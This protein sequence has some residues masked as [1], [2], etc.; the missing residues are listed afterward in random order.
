VPDEGLRIDVWLWRARLF[1]TRAQAASKAGQGMIRLRRDGLESRIDKPSRTVRP[2]DE[3]TFGN[4]GRV[5]AVRILAL[6]A[7]RGPAA[8]ARL[9]FE[10]VDE[11]TARAIDNRAG[12]HR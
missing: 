5:V 11:G 3:L 1:K 12:G 6:G 10:T 7:R 4:A 9:L 2:G 8:E